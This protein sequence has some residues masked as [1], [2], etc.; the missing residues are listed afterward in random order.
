[1]LTRK[2]MLLGEIAVGKTSLARRLVFNQFE[3]GYKA[4]LGVELYTHVVDADASTGDASPSVKLS[5]WD[6][7]GDLAESIF[8]HNYIKG[9]S[10]ALVIGDATRPATVESM[11]RL[12]GAFHETQFGRPV[13]YVVNKLDALDGDLPETLRATLDDPEISLFQTSAL[14][15]A[16]VEDAFRGLAARI[17][18]TG[19]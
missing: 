3:A 15:G 1:V 10:G 2:V 18:S 4:T 7:D 14:T 19:S 17:V 12:A 5:I 8:S 16:R 13:V 6:V 11:V 9:A